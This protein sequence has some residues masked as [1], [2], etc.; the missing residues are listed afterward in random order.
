MPKGDPVATVENFIAAYNAGDNESVLACCHDD[1]VITHHNRGVKIEGKQAF[2]DT[3]NVFKD[4]I[5]NKK[6]SDRR[7]L[8][9]DGGNVIVEHTWGGTAT[10]DIPGFA[11]KGE[12]LELDLAT[13][14]SIKDGLITE[15]HDYG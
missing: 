7:A 12:T 14:Y 4:L 1:V 6:F 9:A 3:L 15:Y 8:F 13:R 5:P 2:R 10:T 11:K